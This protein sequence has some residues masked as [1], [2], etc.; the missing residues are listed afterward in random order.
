MSLKTES[1]ASNDLL[2]N[3]TQFISLS[4]TYTKHIVETF[5]SCNENKIFHTSNTKNGMFN[6]AVEMTSIK[7]F[8]IYC[9][10]LSLPSNIQTIEILFTFQMGWP[11]Y[12]N[13]FTLSR[14]RTVCK[15]VT[16]KEDVEWLLGSDH[17]GLVFCFTVE[18]KKVESDNIK[19]ITKTD[20]INDIGV[21]S[22]PINTE[23]S[24]NTNNT[25][26][27][28]QDL[29]T[30]ITDDAINSVHA[31][32]VLR[33]SNNTATTDITASPTNNI[34]VSSTNNISP[35]STDNITPSSTN[36][37]STTNNP[38]PSASPTNNIST[39][40]TLQSTDN[41]YNDLTFWRNLY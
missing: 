9:N 23:S 14:K 32:T 1:L 5:K 30:E 39:D 2:A 22:K 34:S 15:L 27:I 7:E 38:I 10:L 19:T 3:S 6:F 24:I 17:N 40:D 36:N 28:I 41:L 31:E 33:A 8:N 26:Q 11:R 16:I 21:K 35:S 4:T 37:I 13:T 18:V 29:L 12:P 25:K 20:E